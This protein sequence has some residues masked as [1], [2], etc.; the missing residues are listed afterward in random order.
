M[1]WSQRHGETSFTVPMFD[2][3]MKRQMPDLV[4]HVPQAPLR[5]M[6]PRA[7]LVGVPPGPGVSTA[8][9]GD[10]EPVDIERGGMHGVRTRTWSAR[11]SS[12]LPVTLPPVAGEMAEELR[13]AIGEEGRPIAPAPVVDPEAGRQAAVPGLDEFGHRPG[14]L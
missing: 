8:G 6:K 9:H 11:G 7:S 1:V 3:F 12:S 5:I 14:R 10:Q 13:L 4:R 2:G